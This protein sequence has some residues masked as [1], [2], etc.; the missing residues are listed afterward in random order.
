[1]R[2]DNT[3]LRMSNSF[4]LVRSSKYSLSFFV[5]SQGTGLRKDGTKGE[6]FLLI[7]VKKSVKRIINEG[8]KIYCAHMKIKN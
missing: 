2:I 3:V 1:M 5:G 4:G 8:I 6:G 7:R